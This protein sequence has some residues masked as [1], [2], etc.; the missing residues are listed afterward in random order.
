MVMFYM[1][2]SSTFSKTKKRIFSFFYKQKIFSQNFQ[3][4]RVRKNLIWQSMNTGSCSK[5]IFDCQSKWWV[6]Y[7][8]IQ[9]VLEEKVNLERLTHL[10][11]ILKVLKARTT[12]GQ[13]TLEYCYNF[14]LAGSAV[15]KLTRKFTYSEALFQSN[16]C[17][18]LVTL[19]WEK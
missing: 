18:V 6:W 9:E 5:I 14:I 11:L 19:C 4:N 10:R 12:Y 2:T 7:V 1:W 15:T 16:Y 17:R 3:H 13:L 8:H